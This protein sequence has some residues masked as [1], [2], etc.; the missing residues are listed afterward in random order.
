[1]SL[2]PHPLADTLCNVWHARAQSSGL[3]LARKGDGTLATT[4]DF[5]QALACTSRAE[6]F[7]LW[8]ELS[9]TAQKAAKPPTW[10]EKAPTIFGGMSKST[11][12]AGIT[13]FMA[14]CQH[15]F[16]YAKENYN[17]G[18]SWALT[19]DPAEAYIFT[20]AKK[21]AEAACQALPATALDPTV[22]VLPLLA[23]F[24]PP[25]SVEDYPVD[26]VAGALAAASARASIEC[27][28]TPADPH[29]AKPPGKRPGL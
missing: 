17:S 26:P 23:H 1:M 16:V 19:S 15:R 9:L 25:L 21:A 13:L 7:R 29:P 2:D 10:S 24:A 11:P 14:V 5:A 4:R 20:S 18:H 12:P 28:L 6:A 27:A 22:S 8:E 3:W